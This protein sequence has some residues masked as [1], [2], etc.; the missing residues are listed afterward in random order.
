M[1][2]KTTRSTHGHKDKVL[3]QEHPAGPDASIPIMHLYY[4]LN[5]VVGIDMLRTY[6]EKKHETDKILFIN[7]SCIWEK[8]HHY[9]ILSSL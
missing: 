6:I 8:D 2:D 7:F 1:K 3:D 9:M 4:F 5:L